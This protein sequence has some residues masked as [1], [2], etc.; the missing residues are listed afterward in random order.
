MDIIYTSGLYKHL[1]DNTNSI[2]IN[3]NNINVLEDDSSMLLTTVIFNDN[4]NEK[5]DNVKFPDSI[6]SI[7]FGL[8]F[9]QSLDNVRWP[10]LLKYLHFSYYFE[11]SFDFIPESVECLSIEE[12]HVLSFLNL[13]FNLKEIKIN[14]AHNKIKKL[15]EYNTNYDLYKKALPSYLSNIKIILNN[16]IYTHFVG[17]YTHTFDDT[18]S[19]E[20]NKNNINVLYNKS[21]MSLTTLIFSDTF[22]EQIETFKFPD[23]ITSIIFG[24]NFN[25]SLENVSWPKS[26]KYVHFCYYFNWSL[27]FLP[28]S[29]E[30][31]SIDDNYGL[32]SMYFKNL[33][34]N[35]KKLRINFQRD[36]ITSWDE[37][38]FYYDR[39]KEAL[40]AHLSNVEIII[41]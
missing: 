31:L 18:T 1:V 41:N 13:P 2:I 8:E 39:Y 11:E 40:P 17:N 12:N 30:Y 35:L 23:S 29:L 27:D 21:S 16:E 14:F 4:F 7:I 36:R 34:K 22:N 26:L 28:T 3:K 10:K 33:P 32:D 19:I 20:I 9:N 37:H 24:W 38:D 15:D 6:T 5:I 25:Q